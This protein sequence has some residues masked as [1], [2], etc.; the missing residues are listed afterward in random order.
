[1]QLGDEH[2]F[3]FPIHDRDTKFSRAFDEIFHTEGPC[4]R[5]ARGPRPYATRQPDRYGVAISSAN[6][7][8]DTRPPEFA[9]PMRSSEDDQIVGERGTSATR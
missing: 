8:I 9:N 2:S 5:P 3:R 7:S 4:A 6:L 1:M